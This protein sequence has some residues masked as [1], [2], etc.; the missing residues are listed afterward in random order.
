MQDDDAKM[1]FRCE[2]TCIDILCG[3][4]VDITLFTVAREG[5]VHVAQPVLLEPHPTGS[6]V[7]HPTMR[8]DTPAAQSLIDEL[9]H[10][11]YRPSDHHNTQGEIEA[12]RHHLGD[13]RA[14]AA[15]KLK[16]ELP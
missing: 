4:G 10:C 3:S 7:R 6:I 1:R 5:L 12:I 11:G 9:W 13:M 8:V 15:S 2:R 16:M 14:I